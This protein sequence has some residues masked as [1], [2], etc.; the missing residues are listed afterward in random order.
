M[1]NLLMLEIIA[2]TWDDEKLTQEE[3]ASIKDKYD[4][5]LPWNEVFSDVKRTDLKEKYIHLFEYIDSQ[6]DPVD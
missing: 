6:E 4:K 5:K 3:R 1:R 2:P